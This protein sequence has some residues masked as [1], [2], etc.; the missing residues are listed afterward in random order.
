[1]LGKLPEASS[2]VAGLKLE[3]ESMEIL[4]RMGPREPEISSLTELSP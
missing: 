3:P 4:N 1:M 2:R